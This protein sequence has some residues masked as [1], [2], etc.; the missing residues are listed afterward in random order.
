ME[1][2]IS[3]EQRIDLEMLTRGRKLLRDG[4]LTNFRARTGASKRLLADV[5]DVSQA[6]IATWER[7]DTDVR[8]GHLRQL[9]TFHDEVEV[10]IRLKKPNFAGLV[11]ITGAAMVLGAPLDELKVRCAAGMLYCVDLD[12]LGVW[13]RANAKLVAAYRQRQDTPTRYLPGGSMYNP[14][15]GVSEP[16]EEAP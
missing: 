5:F 12:P 15:G 10:M 3:D 16:V 14:K 8:K 4:W 6:T 7:R 2:L 13:V 9:V 11:P 1:T